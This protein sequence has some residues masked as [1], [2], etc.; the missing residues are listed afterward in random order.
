MKIV[1]EPIEFDWDV[2]NREKN[3]KHRVEDREAEE[4]FLDEKKII[5]RDVFHSKQ[6]KR[7]IVL[8]K[9]RKYRLLYVVFTMRR[10]KI[11]VISARDTNRKEVPIYEKTVEDS[12]I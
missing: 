11:R 2:G 5:Y 4:A 9:T 1:R 8:G 7:W 6:E 12:E 3:K 10:T